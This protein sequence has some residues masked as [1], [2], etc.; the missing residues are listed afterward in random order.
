VSEIGILIF[1]THAIQR[2]FQRQMT[3]TDVRHIL[4]T[5]ENIE[6]YSDDIP[7]PSR[8]VLGWINERPCI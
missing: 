4:T 5:G 6:A 7:Y 3:E 2:M 8:L 1:R